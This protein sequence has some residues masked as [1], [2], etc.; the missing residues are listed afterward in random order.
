ML[1]VIDVGNTNTVIGIFDGKKLIENWRIGTIVDRTTDEYG[2]LFKELLVFSKVRREQIK[3]MIV[4]CVV[5][6]LR[7]VL[8]ELGEKYFHIKPLLVEPGIK[9]GMA[10]R[11]DNPREVGADRI[12]NGVAAYQKYKSS[13]IVIDFGTATTFDFISSDGAYEGGIIAPGL[14]ISSEALFREASKLPRVELIRPKTVIGKNTITAMQSGI[15]FGYAGLVDSLVSRM[16]NEIKDMYPK[17][18]EPRV[19]ATGGLVRLIAKESS[20]IEEVDET[21]TLQGLRIIWNLNQTE[22]NVTYESRKQR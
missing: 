5:P 6:P 17:E 15:I 4:S 8:E 20:T 18:P 7:N 9:T 19:I 12:V 1:L 21:L 11:L 2:I 3:G 13:V 22:T 10:I 14:N 16:K